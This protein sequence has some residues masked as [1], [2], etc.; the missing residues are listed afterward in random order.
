VTTEDSK[1]GTGKNF[2]ARNM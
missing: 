1:G 2:V